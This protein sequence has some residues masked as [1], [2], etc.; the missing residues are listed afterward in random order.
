MKC[1][2]A[3]GKELAATTLSRVS[4]CRRNAGSGSIELHVLGAKRASGSNF[5]GQLHMIDPSSRIFKNMVLSRAFKVK[6]CKIYWLILA[7]T[8]I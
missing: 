7:G 3:Y 2:D 4:H 1:C 6:L 8:I 5:P